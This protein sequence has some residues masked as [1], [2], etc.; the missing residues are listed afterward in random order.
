MAAAKRQEKWVRI[1]LDW[2]RMPKAKVLRFDI[3][4]F[5]QESVRKTIVPYGTNNM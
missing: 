5:S 3:V 4:R 1:T 2:D